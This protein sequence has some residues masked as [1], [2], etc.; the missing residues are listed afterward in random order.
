MHRLYTVLITLYVNLGKKPKEKINLFL[1]SICIN[2]IN[3][4]I[5]AKIFLHTIIIINL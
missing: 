3:K 2:I 1:F 4:K 5:H